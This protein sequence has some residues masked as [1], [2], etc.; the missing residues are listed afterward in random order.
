MSLKKLET[1]QK[2]PRLVEALANI[3]N[4]VTWRAAARELFDTQEEID[5]ALTTLTADFMLQKLLSQNANQS[6][7]R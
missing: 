1:V 6:P 4:H 2:D 5:E 7:R 3:N